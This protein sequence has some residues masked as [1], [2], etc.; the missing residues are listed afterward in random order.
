MQ[1]VKKRN[2]ACYA[3]GYFYSHQV[4]IKPWACG[5]VIVFMTTNTKTGEQDL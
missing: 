1:W 5:S 2:V 4:F 3:S